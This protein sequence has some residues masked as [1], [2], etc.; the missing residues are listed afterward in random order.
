MKSNK[1]ARNFMIRRHECITFTP[2]ELMSKAW[3][4][5]KLLKLTQPAKSIFQ[6]NA[7]HKFQSVQATEE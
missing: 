3:E 1:T 4:S 6:V 7:R 5:I 2:K